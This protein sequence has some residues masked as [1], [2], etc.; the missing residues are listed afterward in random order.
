MLIL[1]FFFYYNNQN[2]PFIKFTLAV[3]GIMFT[4]FAYDSIWNIFYS[5]VNPNWSQH[6]YTMTLFA[7]FCILIY[8]FYYLNK[9]FSFIKINWKWIIV[10]TSI[11]ILLFFSLY[12]TDF[13]TQYYLFVNDLGPDPHNFIWLIGK[14]WSF[15][16]LLIVI[17]VSFNLNAH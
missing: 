3:F 1:Y 5:I 15:T 11:M 9:Q 4:Y 10:W 14:I 16:L 6:Y 7:I 2:K 12:S 8:V 13:F 17:P